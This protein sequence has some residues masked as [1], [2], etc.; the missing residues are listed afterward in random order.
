MNR[1]VVL[2]LAVLIGSGSVSSAV[3]SSA[4]DA[5][6]LVRTADV[7]WSTC[8]ADAADCAPIFILQG[9]PEKKGPFTIR[10]KAPTGWRVAPHYHAR[11]ECVTVLAG[12]PFYIGSGDAIDDRQ[13]AEQV[14]PGDFYCMPGGVHHF[15][16]AVAETVLQ[17]QGVGPD[18]RMFVRQSGKLPSQ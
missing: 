7:R 17:V 5:F 2:I 12:G 9:D 13:R 8:P 4:P 16:W 18:E 3:R 14:G 10:M 1:A 15:A 11:D 6:L